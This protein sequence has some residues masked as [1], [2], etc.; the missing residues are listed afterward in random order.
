MLAFLREHGEYLEC[1]TSNLRSPSMGTL[2]V[3]LLTIDDEK[4]EYPYE[5][6][7][8][9]NL[10]HQELNHQED[11]NHLPRLAVASR[12]LRVPVHAGGGCL[13]ICKEQIFL[14]PRGFCEVPE[15]LRQ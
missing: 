8:T 9:T 1:I 5:V 11:S 2:L 3:R 13:P 12:H 4:K 15:L 14:I 7:Q 6:P 10:G